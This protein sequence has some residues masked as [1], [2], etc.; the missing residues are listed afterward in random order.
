MKVT[1]IDLISSDDTVTANF[2]FRNPSTTNPYIIKEIMG[3]DADAITPKFYGLSQS[4]TS[5]YY[6]LSLENREIVLTIAL[7][8]GF[9]VGESYSGLRDKL[10]KGIASSRTGLIKLWFK[11][12]ANVVAQIQG[13]VTRFESVHFSKSPEVKITIACNDPILKS[14]DPVTVDTSAFGIFPKVVDDL[15]TAPHGL[16]FSITFTENASSFLIHDHVTTEWNLIVSYSFL[17]GDKLYL[18]SRPE[19]KFLYLERGASTILLVDKILPNSVWPIIFP[20][21]NDFHIESGAFTWN[22]L[23]H[24]LSYWGV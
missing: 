23:L 5:K 7:N 12:G 19:Q 15:S 1:N 17:T 24:Y 6:S 21:N 20:G 3:L 18:S 9:G 2:S 13:F 22:Y 8:P 14:V 4:S 10:Y 16:E 11:D